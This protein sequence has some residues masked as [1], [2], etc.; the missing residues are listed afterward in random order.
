MQIK[1]FSVSENTRNA[2]GAGF[3]TGKAEC[4]RAARLAAAMF[5]LAACLQPLHAQNRAL[6]FLTAATDDAVHILLVRIPRMMG[7]FAV[8]R[9]DPGSSEF[10]RLHASPIVPAGD[11]AAARVLLGEDYPWIARALQAEDE[12]GVLSRL[13]SDA[14]LA[15]TL[16]FACRPAAIVAGR[17]F[18]DSSVTRGTRYRYRV[19]ILGL[20][21]STLETHERDVTASGRAPL[22]PSGVRCEAGDGQV[23][24]VWEYPPYRGDP[25]DVAVGFNIYRTEQGGEVEK[26]NPVLILRQENVR[27]RTDAGVENGKRYTYRVRA[28]DF[29]GRE[30]PY[31]ASADASPRDLTPPAFPAGVQVLPEEGALLVV[32]RMNLEQDL[33]HYDVFRGDMLNGEYRKLNKDPIPGD[34]T[35]YEDRGVPGAARLYYKV[36]ALDKA[37]NASEFSNAVSGIAADS[38]PPASPGGLAA[39]LDGDFV[40]LRWSPPEDGDLRG[41]YVYQREKA[42]DRYLRLTDKPLPAGTRSFTDRGVTGKGMHAGRTYVYAVSAVDNAWNESRYS[43][44]EITIPD[45]EPPLAPLTCGARDAGDGRVEVFWQPSMSL[46]VAGYRIY[47]TEDGGKAALLAAA[48][49]GTYSLTDS[50][51]RNGGR[52]AYHAAAVDGAGNEGKRA[53]SA[54]VTPRDLAA[55][56]AVTNISAAASREGV[57]V[58]WDAVQAPDLAG[59]NIYRSD[60]PNGSPTKVNA[61]LSGATRFLDRKG[62]PGKYYRVAAVD[63][64]G[65]ENMESRAV[66]ARLPAAPARKR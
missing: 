44:I 36:R 3:R 11:P 15:S 63:D 64:S 34:R 54:A 25:A 5:A 57:T 2:P 14:G 49:A 43:E 62:K 16:S 41:C 35:R 29:I 7:G 26:I 58:A 50:T 56:P 18:T 66:E 59:Y 45:R 53:S 39:S 38:T 28:V 33:S 23:K 31:S 52:Y 24:I 40:A 20:D 19:D 21:G 6:P 65:N 10:A 61:T 27:H 47:R 55:P 9:K 60:L 8:S 37:G 22:E 32:W 13:R 51:A 1:P 30:S 12:H 46:D 48:G 4:R 17:L 42:E